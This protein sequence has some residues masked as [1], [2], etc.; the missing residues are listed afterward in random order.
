MRGG[1]P[2][3]RIFALVLALVCLCTSCAFAAA[4]YTV[5]EKL[6]KQLWAGSGFSGT[7]KLSFET[8]S[9]STAKPIV[10][11]ADY[12]YVRPAEGISEEHR[13]DVELRDGE[14]VR[15][16]M[17][18]QFASD[19]LSLQSSLLGKDWYTFGETEGT[20]AAQTAATEGAQAVLGV[21]GVPSVARTALTLLAELGSEDQLAEVMEPYK[22]RIDVWI[23]GYRQDAVLDKLSDGTTT[24]SVHYAVS[25][26]AIKAEVKQLVLDMLADTRLINLLSDRLSEDEARLFLSPSLQSWYF[27]VIDDIPLIGDLTI[28]RTVTL[29]G[30]TLHLKLAL[31]LFDAASGSAMLTYERTKGEGDLPDNNLIRLAAK[32]RETELT[33][34]EY[35]SMTGVKVIQGAFVNR[36]PA[37]EQP[38]LAASF[39]LKHEESSTIDAE[40]R[41]VYRVRTELT[42][43]PDEK[44]EN[45]VSFKET[46][47]VWDAAFMSKELKSAATEVEMSLA[48]ADDESLI[49][50]SFEGA[51]R[52]KWEPAE[53]PSQRVNVNTLAEEDL[54][55]LLTPVVFRLSAALSDH[56][57]F[58]QA[59]PAQVNP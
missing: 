33:Y 18:V 15:S 4:D 12:I 16:D 47:V 2:V 32:E 1:L 34:Q 41:D 21:T 59:E 13:V 50:L 20:S 17:H 28:S 58:A 7:L 56:L 39:T 54:A 52:K 48:L 24:M 8:P 26:A 44:T 36:D 30:D 25:P 55:A 10:L 9:V 51:S 3:K 37:G 38:A 27:R 11:D 43:R 23:E 19:A 31:P 45:A 57:T 22:T 5:A 49:E 40:S 42:V 46:D 6:M 53:V 14:T 35:S 29:K